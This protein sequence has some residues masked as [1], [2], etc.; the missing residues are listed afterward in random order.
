MRRPP[1]R[2]SDRDGERMTFAVPHRDEQVIELTLNVE[3][4]A[5]FDEPGGFCSAPRIENE[6][7]IAREEHRAREHPSADAVGT[8][9]HRRLWRGHVQ[10]VDEHLCLG[11]QHDDV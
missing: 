9:V 8:A 1:E 10:H 7:R 4:G 6:R 11:V 5:C 3:I 2:A